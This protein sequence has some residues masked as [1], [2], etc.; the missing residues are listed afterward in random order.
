[1]DRKYL[2][3]IGA[4]VLLGA[5]I[6]TYVFIKH[7][8]V[9]PE[10]AQIVE[11]PPSPPAP[12]SPPIP[13]PAQIPVAV[14]PPSPPLPLLAKSD[15]FVFD[16]LAGL[17]NN[18]SLIKLFHI[19]RV[20]H[21]IVATIVN[22]PLSRAPSNLLPFNPPSRHFLTAGYED[23]LTINPNNHSRYTSY[24]KIAEATDAKKLVALYVRLYPL[25]QQSY[26]ELGY[27]NYYFNEQL[28][29][30][31]DDL[32]ETPVVKE[33][34]KLVQPKYFYLFANPDLEALSVGQKIMLRLG[35]K[36]TMIIKAKLTEIKQ[37]LALNMNGTKLKKAN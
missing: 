25:F 4:F 26:E 35:N 20:I 7:N 21:K 15:N 31:L 17:L 6:A 27:R 34:I 22:L 16:R 24:V 3:A 5:G 37:E 11:A 33:P 28:I 19:K 9:K 30:T 13:V 8:Q 1:M 2:I 10:V 29:E 18:Q 36:N 23:H 14:A 32:L 12:V